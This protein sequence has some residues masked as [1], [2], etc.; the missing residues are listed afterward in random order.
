MCIQTNFINFYINI[1]SGKPERFHFDMDAIRDNKLV[2]P[3]LTIPVNG[4][5]VIVP[6]K[7]N[8]AIRLD[9]NRQYV[10][11]G[12]FT[13]ACLGN[14]EHCNHGLTGSMWINFRSL[15]E[16]AYYLSSGGGLRIYHSGG[17][18]W[19]V[20]ERSGKR[21]EVGVPNLKTDDWYFLEYSWHP[22]KGLQVFVNNKLMGEA[23]Q[24]TT[25]TSSTTSGRVLIG[26]ANSGDVA[27]G[28]FRYGDAIIDEVETWYRDR[29]DLI[30]FNYL[31][32][33][34]FA[35]S[36]LCNKGSELLIKIWD[37]V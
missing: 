32:R 9:G 6:G 11:I 5:P 12:D 7:V 18:L 8:G 17:K 3:L 21:W 27:G 10:D 19:I 23:K 14:M 29:E 25:V 16:N 4:N 30:A 35:H 34:K 36:H 24:S 22:E 2:H 26:S 31:L 13:K 37:V 15:N 1:F 33:G 28:R 20:L